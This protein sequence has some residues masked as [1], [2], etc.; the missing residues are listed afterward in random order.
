[1]NYKDYYLKVCILVS[2]GFFL[3]FILDK[4]FL[5]FERLFFMR[6]FGTFFYR[7]SIRRKYSFALKTF[8]FVYVLKICPLVKRLRFLIFFTKFRHSWPWLRALLDIRYFTVLQV[9]EN[10]IFGHAYN[11]KF[12]FTS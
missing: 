10:P 2:H 8:L 3:I 5:F 4:N 7:T 9:P 1:M 12:Y 11:L 6:C